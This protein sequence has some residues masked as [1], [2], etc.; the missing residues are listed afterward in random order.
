[1][2]EKRESRRKASQEYRERQLALNKEEYKERQR[3]YAR[4]CFRIYYYTN[5]DY[6]EKHKK[7]AREKAYYDN[8]KNQFLLVLRNLFIT[9]NITRS[10]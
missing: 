7:E 4:K 9:P 2:D 6:R 1:M 5:D 8:S 10:T 3:G